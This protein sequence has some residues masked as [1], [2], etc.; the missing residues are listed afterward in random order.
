MVNNLS[1]GSAALS[2]SPADMSDAELLALVEAGNLTFN[3]PPKTRA[4]AIWDEKLAE[5]PPHKIAAADKYRDVSIVIVDDQT[6]LAD[7]L[8]ATLIQLGV[9]EERIA[10]FDSTKDAR[11]FVK[12]FGVTEENRWVK[13]FH[14]GQR[15]LDS[16]REPRLDNFVAD[17]LVIFQDNDCPGKG[18]GIKFINWLDA[19]LPDNNFGSVIYSG[20][21]TL[22]TE[23]QWAGVDAEFLGKPFSIA[24]V[25]SVLDKAIEKTTKKLQRTE[26]AVVY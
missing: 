21:R 7:A 10:I 26:V 11:S 19:Y 25:E 12:A 8:A 2:T 18:S 13:R 23:P 9:P 5:N 22:T 24:K 20:N 15:D 16:N 14:K 17:K 1:E 3:D 4:E 6:D